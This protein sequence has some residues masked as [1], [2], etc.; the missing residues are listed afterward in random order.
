MKRTNDRRPRAVL[1]PRTKRSL[2]DATHKALDRAYGALG[3]RR[4]TRVAPSDSF[5]KTKP[6]RAK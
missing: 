5:A 3:I 1:M 2:K 6:R 4:T